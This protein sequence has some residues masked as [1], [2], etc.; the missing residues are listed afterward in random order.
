MSMIYIALNIIVYVIDFGSLILNVRK[1][2]VSLILGIVEGLTEFLPISSTGHMILVENVLNCMDDSVIAFTVIIQLGAIL[3]I[4]KIFWNQL[5]GMSMI[6]IKKMFF[7]QH[8]DTNHLCIRHIFLGTFPGIML[9]MIFYE[10]IGLIFELTYIMY[11]LIIG[12]IFLLVGEL[13]VSKEP[14]VSDI[15]SIT[16]LQAFLIGCFQC[17]AF[18]PG[19]SRAGATIGGGLV[20]GLNRRISSEFSFFLAVPIIFGSAVLTLYHN[21]SCIGFMDAL[22]LIV[23]SAI[24]FFIALFTVRYFLKIVQNVSLIPFAIYRFLLAGGIYWGLMT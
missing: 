5:Y 23:G 11:G 24:A 15:N 14:R 21:R 16:Y 4:T 13:C 2:A 17:L 3:S 18:W 20:V 6:C 7:K 8:D 10:K 12:G 1:L 9:G 22:L 19:F